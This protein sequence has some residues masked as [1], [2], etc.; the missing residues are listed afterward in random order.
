MQWKPF[1]KDFFIL[2]ANANDSTG[3]ALFFYSYVVTFFKYINHYDN[4]YYFL[5]DGYSRD[6][7]EMPVRLLI[8]N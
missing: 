3:C 1:L 6:I 8:S 4:A 7:R 5:F 2:F